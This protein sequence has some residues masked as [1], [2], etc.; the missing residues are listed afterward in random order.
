MKAILD[1]G[2][3][4]LTVIMM[5]SVGLELKLRYFRQLSKDSLAITTILLTQIVLIPTVGILVS[6][7]L[8]LPPVVRSGILLIAACPVGDTANFFTLMG[9][10]DLAISVTTSVISCLISPVSMTIIFAA[11]GRVLGTSFAFATPG[12]GLVF[13]FFF[14][15]SVPMA[16]G[17]GVRLANIP[18]TDQISRSVRLLS[19]IGIL[20]IVV[21]VIVSRFHQLESDWRPAIRASVPLALAAMMLGWTISR[22]LKLDRNRSFAFLISFAVRNVGLA[23]T[24]AISIMNRLEYAVFSTIY[25][26][27]EVMLVFAA[28]V[29]FR[30]CGAKWP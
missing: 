5:F 22:A 13:R 29:A 30:L 25:F 3:L 20:A 4:G 19:L 12:W 24:I 11:Y 1:I 23:A 8:D 21:Y 9:T 2:V 10:G 28:I 7:I 18:R 15:I 16:A 27:S 14:L 17:I 26:L 6:Q